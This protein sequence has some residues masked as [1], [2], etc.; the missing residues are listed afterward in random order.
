MKAA[1]KIFILLSGML[2]SGTGAFAQSFAYPAQTAAPAAEE[3]P[4][5][6][7]NSVISSDKASALQASQDEKQY[8]LVFYEDFKIEHTLSGKVSCSMKLSVLPLTKNKLSQL[9]IQLIW[10]EIRSSSNFYDI[11]PHVK[12]YKEITLLGEGCYSIDKVPNIVSNRCRIKGM[13]SEEC[14]S[15]LTWSRVR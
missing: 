9:S 7:Y 4:R 12:H 13:T 10:P 6:R 15:L 8:I 14:A 1:Y 3:S 2:L 11:P 5:I